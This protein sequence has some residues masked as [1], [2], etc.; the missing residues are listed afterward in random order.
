M[1]SVSLFGAIRWLVAVVFLANYRA[2]IAA[3]GQSTEPAA[4]GLPKV[5]SGE[6]RGVIDDRAPIVKLPFDNRLYTLGY[7]S[8]LAAGNLRDALAVARAAVRQVP[9]HAAWR[10]RLAQLAEWTGDPMLALEQWHAYAKLSGDDNAWEKVRTLAPAL[11]DYDRWLEALL[12]QLKRQP[13]SSPATAALLVDI[14][15]ACE[16]L[17]KPQLAIDI[18]RPLVSGPHQKTVLSLLAQLADNVGDDQLLNEIL[19]TWNRI[20]PNN[21]D[22]ALRFAQVQARRGDKQSAFRTLA[23]IAT[24]VD[25]RRD[26]FWNSYLDFALQTGQRDEAVRICRARIES[27]FAEERHYIVLSELLAPDNFAAAADAAAQ[28]YHR[29]GNT[30]LAYRAMAFYQR[31][32]NNRAALNFIQTLSASQRQTLERDPTF[33][34]Q[35]ALIELA[36]KEPQKALTLARTALHMQPDNVDFRALVVWSLIA[37]QEASELRR[38]LH[39]WSHIANLESDLWAPFAAGWL[40]L[41]EPHEALRYLQKKIKSTNDPLWWLNYADAL[42]LA[43][44][45][46]LAWRVRR[47]AWLE[48]QRTPKKHNEQQD[49]IDGRLVALALIFEGSDAARQRLQQLLLKH[50]TELRRH[51]I[52]RVSALT[53]A[54]NRGTIE[55]AQAWLLAGYAKALERPSWAQLSVA[56][57]NDDRTELQRLLD[58]IA[59]WLP[60]LDQVEANKRTGRQAQAQ[61]LAFDRLAELPYYDELHSRLVDVTVNHSSSV[62]LRFEL[63]QQDPLVEQHATLTGE[64]LLTQNLKLSYRISQL[65]RRSRDA[66]RLVNQLAPEK[67]LSFTVQRPLVGNGSIGATLLVRNGSYNDVGIVIEGGRDITP[68]LKMS[69]RIALND[70][71]TDNVYFRI[72]GRRHTAEL[73]FFS[74]ISLR[75]YIS[76]SVA[77]NRYATLGGGSIGNGLIMRAEAGH[78]VRLEYPELSFRAIL[79]R[80]IYQP[81]LGLDPRL[82][83]LLPNP[84][85]SNIGF[86]PKSKTQLGLQIDVGESA[87]FAYTRALRPWASLGLFYDRIDGVNLQWALGFASSVMGGDLLEFG[88][89]GN[90]QNKVNVKSDRRYLLQYRWLY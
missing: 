80:S 11:F 5:Q 12:R 47:Y 39:E 69:A 33:F 27:G 20:E 88:V 60:K 13:S 10:R 71:A 45:A 29:F 9:G 14:V 18:L 48:L 68:R 65:T 16:A 87:R 7:E 40:L 15:Q 75:E 55:L 17:G 72:A 86:F 61:T 50:R 79:A 89:S 28:G 76:A 6:L 73:S 85:G 63:T 77:A 22:L 34:Y 49:E 25:T 78:R 57:A 1:S 66:D 46:D 84:P 30:T 81:A 74:P 67:Q 4:N 83:Q 32:G 53:Y 21:V 42:D 52:A 43:G 70:I 19:T 62:G 26:D 51:D 3:S 8:F 82:A 54:I 64:A 37:L 59:D 31:A 41:Q 35:W 56:L 44:A 38:T 23:A 90:M 24:H 2:V 36:E 58:T